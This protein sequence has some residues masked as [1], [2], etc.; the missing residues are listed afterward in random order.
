MGVADWV[1]ALEDLIEQAKQIGQ[2]SLF[3]TG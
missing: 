1:G 3:G 2:C